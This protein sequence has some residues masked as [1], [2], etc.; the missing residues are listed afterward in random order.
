MERKL[1]RVYNDGQRMLNVGL[2]LATDM[3]ILLLQSE[4]SENLAWAIGE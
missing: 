4:W 1:G 2:A 3:R